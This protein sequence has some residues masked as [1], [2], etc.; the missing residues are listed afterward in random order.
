M[1]LVAKDDAPSPSHIPLILTHCAAPDDRLEPDHWATLVTRRWRE[2]ATLLQC[3]S[4]Q[5]FYR[6]A[7]PEPKIWPSVSIIIP[8]RDKVELLSACLAGLSRLRYPGACEIIVVD[9][10]TTQPAAL[11]LLEELQADDTVQVIRDDGPFNFSA[12]NNRAAA[13]AAGDVFCLLNN[14]VEA[15]D[16]DWLAAMVRHAVRPDVGA[17]GSML[18]YP[19]GSVQHAGVAIGIG[20]AAG[21]LARGAMPTDPD[22]FAWHGVTRSV[23]AVT[24]ACLVVRREA[25]FS[26]GGLDAAAFPVAFNDV[27]F[28]LKLQQSGLR[29]VFVAEARL[30]HHE[31]VSRGKDHAPANIERFNG[32][33]ARFRKRWG[34]AEHSDPH[35]SP[36]FSRSAEPCLLAF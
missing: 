34:S 33:L 2:Q 4:Q 6:V 7:P 21:H 20:G 25:Y 16:G 32:E 8:T 19:D 35:Y 11:R 30:I 36:L 28:C 5:P 15:L 14:D 31:S 13:Q 26:V 23:S 9:N 24:A 10:G 29:N 3:G 17:V 12:L 27:D 22:H 1:E 18:L